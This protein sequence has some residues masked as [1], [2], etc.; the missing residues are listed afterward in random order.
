MGV[1]VGVGDWYKETID[2]KAEV[3][4]GEEWNERVR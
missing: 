3:K 2:G 1:G 4:G